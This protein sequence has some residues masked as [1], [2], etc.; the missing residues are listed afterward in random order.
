MVRFRTIAYRES[1]LSAGV[2]KN[3]SQTNA[4]R[5]PRVKS[6]SIATRTNHGGAGFELPIPMVCQE[7]KYPANKSR[8]PSG[9][10]KSAPPEIPP[11]RLRDANRANTNM[12]NPREN[13][14]TRAILFSKVKLPDG[15]S[16]SSSPTTL[17]ASS[18]EVEGLASGARPRNISSR[19]E[20]NASCICERLGARYGKTDVG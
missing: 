1:A 8:A 4:C 12:V 3:S 11:H 6:E 2:N 14:G 15:S 17:L 7:S 19:K 9:D 10:L 13:H 18:N 16:S 5:L 20:V